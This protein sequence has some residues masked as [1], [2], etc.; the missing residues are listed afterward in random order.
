MG[1]WPFLTVAVQGHPLI[2]ETFLA[3]VEEATEWGHRLR[4]LFPDVW[5]ANHAFE[6]FVNYA[7]NQR[8]KFLEKKTDAPENMEPRICEF[9]GISVLSWR[10]A[11]FPFTSLMQNG[12][13][14]SVLLKTDI[15]EPER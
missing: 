5:S 12:V 11:P 2:L 10:K 6:S 3:P 1:G 13:P 15:I 8:Q 9:W 4:S 14:T 7:H